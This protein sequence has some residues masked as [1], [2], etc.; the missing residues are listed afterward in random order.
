MILEITDTT[1]SHQ[2]PAMR[3]LSVV[4][5]QKYFESGVILIL[6]IR[7][8]FRTGIQHLLQ[9]KSHRAQADLGTDQ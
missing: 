5:G 1:G 9:T 8:C 4:R 3:R 6:I 7:S 2:F